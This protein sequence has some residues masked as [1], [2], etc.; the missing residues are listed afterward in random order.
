MTTEAGTRQRLDRRR[1]LEAALNVVDAE[2]LDALTMRRLGNELDVDPMTVHHHAKGKD[3]LLDGLAELLWEEIDPPPETEDASEVLR[4][5]ARSIRE[6]FH[7]HPE[8][9]PLLLRCS[10]LCQSQLELWR[11]YLDALAERGLDEPAAVLRPVL[12][13]AL[14]TAYAE[15]AM[16]ALQCEPSESRTLSEREMLLYLGQALPAGTP[17]E[18][19]SA[20]V[21]MIADCNPDRCFDDG[22][23][24]MLAGLARSSSRKS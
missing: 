15:V 7:R 11:A 6:L 16:L 23:E 24:L 9:A 10:E 22:L 20:A 17:P 4:A 1:V 3:G 12:F 14:G 13:Y 18:L 2:G 21:E 5:L 19:V 8:A